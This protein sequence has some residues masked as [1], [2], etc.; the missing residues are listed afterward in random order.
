MIG[1]CENGHPNKEGVRFCGKC[2]KPIDPDIG[3]LVEE[4][5]RKYEIKRQLGRGG[6]GAVYEALNANLGRKV[7]IKLMAES[8]LRDAEFQKR[9][10]R[11]V[12][13]TAK[14]PKHPNIV[15]VHD[16]GEVNDRPYYI[17]EFAPQN[18]REFMEDKG[19]LNPDEATRIG[20][21][22]LKGLAAL[23][24][25]GLVHRDIKPENILMSEDGVPR[26]TDFGIAKITRE[27]MTR[28][29]AVFGSPAYMSPEQ[30]VDSS[31]VDA[32]SDLFAVGLMIYE[33]VLGKH[34]YADLVEGQGKTYAQAASSGALPG[35]K[36]GVRGFGAAGNVDMSSVSTSAAGLQSVL[37]KAC[38]K[39]PE[40]RYASANDFIEA[41]EKLRT[42]AGAGA[43]LPW[44]M[45]GKVAGA[46]I[47]LGVLG[48]GGYWAINNLAT[49][50]TADVEI[51]TEPVAGALIRIRREGEPADQEMGTTARTLE[52][53]PGRYELSLVPPE[54]LG[55]RTASLEFNVTAD[56]PPTSDLVSPVQL[57]CNAGTSWNA[58][59]RI[60]ERAQTPP[61][62]GFRRCPPPCPTGM[63]CIGGVCR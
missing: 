44:G 33:M 31:K 39:S 58:S 1:Y 16:Y 12:K 59:S 21:G 30:H 57:Q 4:L 52:L 53:E 25:Q 37:K 51:A 60:C 15:E 43:G 34:P 29:G 38:A 9:F 56:D 46:V 6:M 26:I 35:L 17:M 23:H 3:L 55:L 20:V 54:G 62:P 27:D 24:A 7:A 18:L 61:T 47:A 50:S 28:V 14:F 2:G 22:I 48:A 13:T 41:L 36:T 40:S 5:G 8:M 11:E 42:S 45:I 49:S 63:F 19:V 10:K 32:R